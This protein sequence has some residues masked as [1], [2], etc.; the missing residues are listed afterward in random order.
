[1]PSEVDVNA[2]ERFELV[3]QAA[4]YV[5]VVVRPIGEATHGTINEIEIY[6]K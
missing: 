2:N 6:A 3:P 5:R 4:K 1:M